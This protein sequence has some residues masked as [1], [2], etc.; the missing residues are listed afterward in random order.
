MMSGCPV[1]MFDADYYHE[2]N[3][4]ADYFTGYDYAIKLLEKYLDDDKYR[5]KKAQESLDYVR[6]NLTWSTAIKR[7]SEDIDEV[8]E[9]TPSANPNGD[10]MRKLLNDLKDKGTMTKRELITQR[11]GS[12]IKF[13]PYRRALMEHPNV[14]DTHQRISTYQWVDK[15][16]EKNS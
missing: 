12:G 14:M 1:I 5:D 4:T 3:P 7:L 2:L 15:K 13:T 16:D 10:G 8:I 9:S 6:E 11:W